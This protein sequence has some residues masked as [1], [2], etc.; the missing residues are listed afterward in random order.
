MEIFD[1]NV[2]TNESA[3]F[4][5]S[6]SNLLDFRYMTKKITCSVCKYESDPDLF[7]GKLLI[8]QKNYVSDLEDE[9]SSIS[10]NDDDNKIDEEKTQK[11]EK[12]ESSE[13]EQL[14]VDERASITVYCPQCEKERKTLF[15]TAQLRSVDEG[16]TIFYQCLTCNH[17]WSQHN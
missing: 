7:E 8:T 16:Q 3:F 12:D 14:F 10:S 4:C 1:F 9:N 17:K 5:P 11:T 15:S 13:E 6:C 2:E